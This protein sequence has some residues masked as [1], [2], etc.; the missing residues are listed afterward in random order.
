MLAREAFDLAGDTVAYP[1]SATNGMGA[2]IPAKFYRGAG[3]GGGGQPGPTIT[4]NVG[5]YSPLL[6]RSY[7]EIAAESRS[8]HLSQGQ[9][10]LLPKGPRTDAVRLEATHEISAGASER[11][12]FDGID[13][14]AARF[15]SVA[16]APGARSA[17]DSLAG[18]RN[19]V[20]RHLDLGEPSGMVPPLA[21][22]L[23]LVQRA[24]QGVEACHRALLAVPVCAGLRGD[25]AA[26]LDEQL[27]RATDAL[28]LAAGVAIDATAPRELVANG[29]SI[30]VTIAVYNQGRVPVAYLG[31][32]SADAQAGPAVS[33]VRP[34][35]IP[36]DSVVQETF[37]RTM[38]GGPTVSWW[39]AL[40]SSN[41]YPPSDMFRLREV[42]DT[43]GGPIPPLIGGEDRVFSSGVGVRLEI[44]GVRFSTV[45]QPIVYRHA[46][47]A[48]GEERRAIAAVPAI[49]I[50]LER[51]VEYVRANA[52][53][54]RMFRVFVHSDAADDRPVRVSLNLPR[55]LTADSGQ[56]SVTLKPRTSANMFFHVRGTLKP[57]ESAISA[58]ATSNGQLFAAGF[59][60]IEYAH[61]RPLRFYRQAVMKLQAVDVAYPE[62]MTIAYLQGVGDNVEPMLEQLGLTVSVLDPVALPQ[63]DLSRF[64][65]VVVGPRAFGAS[66]ALVA[67]N[68][69]LLDYVRRG[70]TLVEQ[71]GRDEMSR[72]GIPP[73]PMSPASNAN[74]VTEE[75]APVRVLD[76]AS[77]LLN[78]PNRITDADFSDWVQERAS[79]MP[80][81]FDGRYHTVLS[82]NDTSEP[83]NDAAILTAA[84]GKGTY[85]YTTLSFFRQL[86]AGNPGAARL[87]VNLLSA[88]SPP[89]GRPAP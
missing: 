2:W 59:I 62:G 38:S 18:A 26:S 77:P 71:Y 60:P 23:S 30:P 19:D 41:D 50:L 68:A 82:M 70:G 52:P 3:R 63:T 53:L 87:F 21:R 22:Y 75:D 85:V 10:S 54:D 67:H 69:L 44:A 4:F 8:Q 46:D 55:G 24:R 42:R 31:R 83:P 34:R 14:S 84:I 72:L 61:I 36:P 56:R 65:A 76:P 73:Y 11:S 86:P 51:E 6:G 35:V 29:D 33:A 43:T 78:T 28:L 32:D 12:I 66:D 17:L 20:L 58:T 13:T 39:M 7:A 89:T 88:G 57:G 49:T 45:V 1:R 37:S 25:L 15:A 40:S 74:R 48:H 64:Q 16:L 5:E 81:T 9:G 47:P 80:P 79:Y 27:R